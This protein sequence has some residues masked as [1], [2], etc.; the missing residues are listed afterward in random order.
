MVLSER[1]RVS[2]LSVQA[3]H[4]DHEEEADGPELRHRHHGHSSGVGDEGQA[5][6]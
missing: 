2:H 1:M 3:Q 6:P 5:G 4:D